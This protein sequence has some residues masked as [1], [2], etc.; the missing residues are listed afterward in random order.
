MP[1]C[2]SQSRPPFRCGQQEGIGVGGYPLLKSRFNPVARNIAVT[3]GR[4]MG[5]VVEGSVCFRLV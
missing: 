4:H 2:R 3:T 5:P 1:V